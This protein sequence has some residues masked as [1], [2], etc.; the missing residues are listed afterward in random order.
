MASSL[1]ILTLLAIA[2]SSVCSQTILGSDPYASPG[3]TRRNVVKDA[4]GVLYSL[5]VS[6]DASGNRP[7]LLQASSDG[8]LTWQPLPITLNDASSGLNPPN[9]TNRCTLA[10][11]DQ[12]TLHATWGFNMPNVNYYRLFYRNY[13]PLT[14]T[15]SAIVNMGQVSSAG[16]A[17]YYLGDIQVDANGIL[18][19]TSQGTSQYMERLVRSTQPY[20]QGLTFQDLG[21]LA[22]SGTAQRSQVMIDAQGLVH[23]AY[24][25]TTTGLWHR[26]YNPASGWQPTATALGNSTTP[27]DLWAHMAADA[28]GRVH[29][30]VA[31]DSAGGAPLQFNY[32][33]WEQATGWSAP[34]IFSTLPLAQWTGVATYN[35]VDIACDEATGTVYLVFRDVLA[36]G[37]LR[38]FA[39][40]LTDPA[41]SP[42]GDIAPP[43]L[44]NSEYNLPRLRGTLYPASN[45][46]G[47]LLDV[48]WRHQPATAPP[49]SMMFQ[50]VDLGAPAA[51]IALGGP[52]TVGGIT[53]LDMSSPADPNGSY[54]CALAA[55]TVPGIPLADGRT[56]PLNLD[57]LLLLTLAAGNPV[58][59]NNLGVLSPSGAASAVLAVPNIPQL[60]GLTVHAA[61][62]VAD[63]LAPTG[64]GTISPSLPITVQ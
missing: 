16:T 1:R 57:D 25:S 46:T 54:A 37:M 2:T 9:P 47:T 59:L 26:I 61:F 51:S 62:V 45:N 10:I 55:G 23:V 6:E 35:I 64:V 7:L 39:K 53:T 20:A 58:L 30:I 38:L 56:I 27:N 15:A 49:F 41:F 5:Y 63:P 24:G 13:N 48:T 3:Q 29:A 34:L 50:R 4:S 42:I 14:A 11:D 33:M 17:P 36:G 12:G 8:G 52:A 60:L 40:G 21:L 22:P 32:R 18:W 19:I 44:G 43:T 31:V 28:G